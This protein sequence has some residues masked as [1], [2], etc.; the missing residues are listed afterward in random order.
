MPGTH[1]SILPTLEELFLRVQ[2]IIIPLIKIFVISF[3]DIV[4]PFIPQV[5]FKRLPHNLYQDHP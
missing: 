5:V 1:I 4:S 2:E 3:V